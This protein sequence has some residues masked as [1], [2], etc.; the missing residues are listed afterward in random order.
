MSIS[1]NYPTIRPSLLLDFANTQALDPRVTFTRSTTGTYYNGYSSAIAEQNLTT[2]SQAFSNT[3]GWTTGNLTVTDNS[4]TAPDGTSTASLAVPDTTSNYHIVY[5]APAITVAA[6]SFTV[7][8]YAKPSSYNFVYIR[9]NLDGTYS[10]TFFNVSTGALG[11]VAAGRTATITASANGY[12]RCTVTVTATAGSRGF[13][14]GV[15]SADNTPVFTGNG[16]SGAYL[17]GAQL[18]QRSSATAYNATTTAAITNYISVLQTAPINVPRFDCDPVS[19]Q[20]LGLLIEQQSTNLLTYSSDFSN[21]YWTKDG[22]TI[23]ADTIIAPDGTQTG[24]KLV[25][26]AATVTHRAYSGALTLSLSPYTYTVYAK[27]G[28]RNWLVMDAQW[29]ATGA[30]YFNLSTGTVGTVTS[31][32]TAS[33]TSVGNGWYRCS[34]TKTPTSGTSYC[35]VAMALSD[36]GSTNYAGNGYAGL[37]IWG[38]QLEAGA[39]STSYI[40]TVASQVTRSADVATMTGTNFS[41]WFNPNQGSLYANGTLI[42][43]TTNSWMYAL[44]GANTNIIRIGAGVFDEFVNGTNTVSASSTTSGSFQTAM[45][46]QNGNHYGV[47]NGAG[48]YSS[49]YANIPVGLSQLTF[50]SGVG[51]Y[52]NG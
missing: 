45:I 26:T 1:V 49:T 27:A 15:C 40:P 2:Y 17:W 38:A 12:Y 9:E 6:G 19:E 11:T 35:L 14:F 34:V 37:Y 16:T 25:E 42:P 32:C 51:S 20:C 8:F 43:T 5:N 47:K 50:S 41:S 29:V 39:F 48:I 33:M 7:S 28:E 10:N 23:T 31:G 18:E 24:D 21:A 44:T 4:T 30:C 36:G 13:N 3:A 52:M 22:T 46:Y